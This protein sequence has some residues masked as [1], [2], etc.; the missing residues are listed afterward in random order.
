MQQRLRLTVVYGTHD[1][2][3]G[4]AVS[5]HII[6]LDQ[7]RIAQSGTP[8]ELYERP[9]SV[10]VAGFMGEAMLFPAR[11]LDDGNIALGP[12]RWPPHRRTPWVGSPWRSGRRPGGW[13]AGAA[14]ARCGKA[15]YVGHGVELT[16]RTEIG[17]VF[18]TGPIAP[19]QALPGTRFSL[20]LGERGVAV[21]SVPPALVPV[22]PQ[23]G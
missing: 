8:R 15:A 14:R 20:A 6:V 7:G 2:A 4:L 3:E 9:Y 23:G 10:F 22:L 12:L 16:L 19:E 1:Q 13:T 5:D 11:G 18:V 21:L 17:D